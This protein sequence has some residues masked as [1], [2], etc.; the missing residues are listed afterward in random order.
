M[1][2]T[3]CHKNLMVGGYIFGVQRREFVD[4]A[5]GGGSNKKPAL[6]GNKAGFLK[7]GD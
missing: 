1:T 3:L 4:F 6:W 2:P 5:P 7:K